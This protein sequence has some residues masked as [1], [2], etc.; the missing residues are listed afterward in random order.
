MSNASDTADG[1]VFAS[2]GLMKWRY[3]KDKLA[4][5]GV[6]VGGI[7]VIFAVVLIF[8]YLLWVVLPIFKPASL[9]ATTQFALP[10][11]SGDRSLLYA[12]DEQGEVGLRVSG[13]GRL[14]FF[15]LSDG[16]LRD[17]IDLDAPL[18]AAS[19]VDEASRKFAVLTETQRVVLLEHQYRLNYPTDGSPRTIT[20]RIEFPYG[21]EGLEAPAGDIMSVREDE[22]LLTLAVA[23]EDHITL[24]QYEKST[25]FFDESV[26]LEAIGDQTLILPRQIDALIMDPLQDWLYAFNYQNAEIYYYDIRKFDQPKLVE[27]VSAAEVGDVITAVNMLS[28]GL[29]LVVATDD[30]KITQYFPLRNEQGTDYTLQRVRSFDAAEGTVVETLLTEQRRRGFMSLAAN[31]TVGAYFATSERELTDMQLEVSGLQIGAISPRANVVLVEHANRGIQTLRLHNE[32]PEVSFKALW[33]KIW[34][35]SYPEP[36]YTWQSSAAN[37]D[38]EPKFSLSP[39]AFGTIKAAFYAM[40]FAVPL[41]LAGAVYTAYFMS[42]GLRQLVKPAIEVMEALPTVILGFLAGLWLAPFIET[43]LP[44][45][46]L[47]ILFLPITMPLTGWLW[48]LTPDS[49][50]HRVPEGWQP[51]LLILPIIVSTALALALSQP[52]EATFFDGSLPHWLDNEMGITY[53][54]RN[55]LVVGLAMGFAVIPTIFSIAEDAVFS[56]PKQLT[57]GSLALGATPW[58]TLVRVVLPTA[59]PGMFSALMIGFGRAVGETMIVLM[60]TGNTPIMD[61][62][63]FEG[64][65]TLSANIAVEMPESEVGSTHFRILFLAGL[66][67]FL[68]TFVFNTLA[69]II[70]QRLRNKYSNL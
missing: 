59:S 43:H 33:G 22:D 52:I 50:R 32:H 62:N 1:T 69:E 47:M 70:R 24:S 15:S 38:F 29:S 40:L 63:I 2:P 3:T 4:A 67:L 13:D 35:E 17:E 36:D 64:F 28:G 20:P 60:A 25:S 46:F 42:S 8:F 58:Q 45:V 44:G 12:I 26:S 54:Q 16:A 7:G 6:T 14:R 68:F 34:Y 61:F 30:G 11:D 5:A 41:A 23:D 66:V 55:S 65:R 37:S 51:L 9:E 19:H 49:V 21:Q 27:T 10:G 57:Q 48:T 18:I 39:L 56:V 53:D 31:G